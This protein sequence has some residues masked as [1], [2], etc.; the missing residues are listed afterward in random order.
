MHL[1]RPTLLLVTTVA[2]VAACSDSSAPDP[3]AVRRISIG[4][5]ADTVWAGTSDTALATVR[6]GRDA[7]V[8]TATVRWSSSDTSLLVVDSVTGIVTAGGSGSA[9]LRARAGGRIDSARVTLDFRPTPTPVPFVRVGEI[10]GPGQTGPIRC[11]LS[12]AGAAWCQGATNGEF[13]AVEGGHAFRDVEGSQ[14]AMCGLTTDDE[15]YCWGDNHHGNL[16]TGSATPTFSA[17]PVLAAGGRRF[18]AMALGSHAVVCG[19][20]KA[21]SLAWCWGHNDLAQTG[22]LPMTT[23]EYVPAPVPGLPKVRQISATVGAACAIAIDGSTWCWGQGYTTGTTSETASA[24]QLAAP[25]VYTQVAA[26]NAF[27]CALTPTGAVDCDLKSPAEQRR[28]VS[29]APPLASIF[30]AGNRSTVCGLTAAG[31]L[32]CW[33]E[34]GGGDQPAPIVARPFYRGKA[35]RQVRYDLGAPC[36]IGTDGKFYC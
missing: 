4:G 34:T 21:D 22:R 16:G 17:T 32:Y 13:T 3:D 1:V 11:G 19:I 2:I 6:D 24:V 12:A 28:R 10:S 23:V 15:M 27:A 7:V 36:G 18:S 26:G 31:A 33:S 14:R 8:D 20:G 25:G 29:G 35:F 5:L 30:E 9:W